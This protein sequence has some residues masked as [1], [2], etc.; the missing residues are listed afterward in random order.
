MDALRED[1]PEAVHTVLRRWH[2]GQQE[3]LPWSEMLTVT[4]RLA[5]SPMPNLDLA[6]EGEA[7]LPPPPGRR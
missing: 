7:S 4:R 3:A 5:A 1:L 6:V 2:T